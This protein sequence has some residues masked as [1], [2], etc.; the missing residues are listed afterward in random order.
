MPQTSTKF[1][2]ANLKGG[3]GKSTLALNLAAGLKQRGN[4]VLLD[5]DPQGTLVHWVNHEKIDS[6]PRVV[7]T[8]SGLSKEIRWAS[9]THQYVVVDCP[10]ALGSGY[11][12]TAMEMVD[13]LLVPVL[14]SP[15]DLWSSNRMVEAVQQ[16][17]KINPK[18]RAYFVRN[19]VEPR[20]ALSHAMRQ[21]LRTC[22]LPSL[23]NSLGRRAAYRWAALEGISVYQ[24]GARGKKA[25][26]DIESII[27]EVLNHD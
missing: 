24:F 27:E 5:A 17:R 15:P 22:D 6:M 14:P 9:S 10:P 19:Q 2:I 23:E 13:I 12:E 7:A 21:V 20:S 11:T 3:C 8:G 25:V 4:T 26:E 1:A 16:A 18:L